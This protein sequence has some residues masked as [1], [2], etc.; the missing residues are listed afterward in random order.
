MKKVLRV[1]Y[2]M[3]I[4]VAVL[5]GS[6]VSSFA[7]ESA[8]AD[9]EVSEAT[10]AESAS[11][12]EYI[13]PVTPSPGNKFDYTSMGH[14]RAYTTSWK[15]LATSTKGFNCNVYIQ[16]MNYGLNGQGF[17]PSNIRM[18]DKNGKVLWSETGAVQGQGYRVFACGS[19]VYTIQICTSLGGG[20]AWA[21]QTDH[22]PTDK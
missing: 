15:T 14:A 16:C 17:A 6:S 21:Y 9:T 18:L 3:A 4:A 20:S 13:A 12:R 8:V 5:F 1:T 19:D 10:V 22:A 7:A 11:T 2:A